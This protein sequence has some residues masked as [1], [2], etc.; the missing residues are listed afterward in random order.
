MTTEN[1]PLERRKVGRPKKEKKGQ[2][3]WI[4]AEYLE[5]VNA[6]IGFLKEHKPRE[7]SK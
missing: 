2:M 7:E 3:M 1:K 4:P 6:Y 5:M